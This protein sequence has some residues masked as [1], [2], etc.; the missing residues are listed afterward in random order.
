MEKETKKFDTIMD[1]SKI[2]EKT[3]NENPSRPIRSF[4]LWVLC[5]GVFSCLGIGIFLAFDYAKQEDSIVTQYM[6]RFGLI[7]KT[8]VA[9]IA[10]ESPKIQSE[11]MQIDIR[12][13][14]G[15]SVRMDLKIRPIFDEFE[16]QKI[17]HTIRIYFSNFDVESVYTNQREHMD[18]VFKLLYNTYPN[19]ETILVEHFQY[20]ARIEALFDQ[21]QNHKVELERAKIEVEITKQRAKVKEME[22]EMRMKELQK[23]REESLYRAKTESMVKDI[24]ERKSK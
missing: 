3:E 19:I 22:A 16:K 2:G 24:L 7:E 5:F 1:Y 11:L 23:Q 6:E 4:L 8:K 13:G 18:S 12:L 10:P 17:K 15:C 14:D 21:R 20:E 9:A